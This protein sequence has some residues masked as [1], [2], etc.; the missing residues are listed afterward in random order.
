[1]ATVTSGSHSKAVFCHRLHL[2]P[3]RQGQLHLLK[4]LGRYP[5]E[6]GINL[7]HLVDEG[8]PGAL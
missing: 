2:E 4:G 3:P 6:V 7:G 1:M 8:R 5:D